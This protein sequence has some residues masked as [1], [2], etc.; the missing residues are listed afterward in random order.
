VVV[1]TGAGAVLERDIG[2]GLVRQL[3]EPVIARAPQPERDR[4]MG[5]AA[6]LAAPIVAADNLDFREG[7]PVDQ[8]AVLHG[9]YWVLANM[10]DRGPLLGSVDD[11]QWADTSSLH[12]LNYLARRLEGM[13][14]LLLAAVR[15]G[16]PEAEVP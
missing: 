14:V 2:F 11:I 12:F 16:E 3:L 1:V 15:S 5:G 4:L 8:P 13:P 6:R 10:T 9:L 7:P